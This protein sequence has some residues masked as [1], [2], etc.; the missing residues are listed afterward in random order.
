MDLLDF[1]ETDYWW[2]FRLGPAKEGEVWME[3]FLKFKAAIP[4]AYRSYIP[5][6][7]HLWGCVKTPENRAALID[8]FGN[9]KLCIET[10]EMSQR[11]PG[12]E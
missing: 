2:H 4:P 9:A 8:I 1:S 10:L 5:H 12:F 6:N 3:I 11:L 7:N